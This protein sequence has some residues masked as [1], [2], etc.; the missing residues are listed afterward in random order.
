MSHIRIHMHLLMRY[1]D[2]G[3][4]FSFGERPLGRQLQSS[5]LTCT[6][7]SAYPCDRRKLLDLAKSRSDNRCFFSLRILWANSGG[8]LKRLPSL[9]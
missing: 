1:E 3:P 2:R 8:R 5:D 4:A 6:K 7:P 9:L